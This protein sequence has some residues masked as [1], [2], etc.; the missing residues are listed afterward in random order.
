MK[1]YRQTFI[2]DPQIGY[3]FQPNLSVTIIGDEKD[4]M[5][6]YKL[7]IDKFGYRNYLKDLTSNDKFIA[8]DNLFIGCSFTAGDGVENESRFTDLIGDSYNAAI[9]GTCTIQQFS[10]AEDCTKF[11]KPKNVIFSPYLGCLSRSYLSQ[12]STYFLSSRH[13]WFKPY[14][15]KLNGEITIKNIP[16]PYPK[17]DFENEFKNKTKVNKINKICKKILKKI[18]LKNKNE[19]NNLLKPFSSK[20]EFLIYKKL[21]KDAKK[22]FPDSEFTLAPIPHYDFLRYSSEY[23]KALIINFFRNLTLE[24]NYNYIDLINPLLKENYEYLYYY[25][26]G[27]LNKKGHQYIAEILKKFI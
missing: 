27:H 4:N 2:F 11:L 18:F 17:I 3:K 1:T 8:I 24:V 22:L 12:R 9:P 16:V 15:K 21:Y 5:Q 26:D 10:I 13:N 25:T 14:L 7:T 20:D 6:D 23:E 19:F